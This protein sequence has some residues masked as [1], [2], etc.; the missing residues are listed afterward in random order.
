MSSNSS[1]NVSGQNDNQNMS[2]LS[3]LKTMFKLYVVG[4]FLVFEAET[5][6]LQPIFHQN[7]SV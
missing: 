4:V 2:K 3:T 7:C 1:L 5:D 6:N